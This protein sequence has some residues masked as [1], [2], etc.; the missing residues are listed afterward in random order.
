MRTFGYED[1][2][3]FGDSMLLTEYRPL[4]GPFPIFDPHQLKVVNKKKSCFLKRLN[5]AT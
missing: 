1:D 5:A 3:P 4:G 2:S